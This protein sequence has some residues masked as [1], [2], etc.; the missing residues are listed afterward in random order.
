MPPDCVGMGAVTAEGARVG[1][2]EVDR[3]GIGKRPDGE[4]RRELEFGAG[5]GTGELARTALGAGGIIPAAGT[6]GGVGRG[7]G[8]STGTA[9]GAAGFGPGKAPVGGRGGGIKLLEDAAPGA[10]D[11]SRGTNSSVTG[12][13][14]SSMIFGCDEGGAI[15]TAGGESGFRRRLGRRLLAQNFLRKRI[16]HA[17]HRGIDGFLIRAQGQQIRRNAHH[18]VHQRQ[19]DRKGEETGQRLDRLEIAGRKMRRPVPGASSPLCRRGAVPAPCSS[20][21]RLPSP[22]HPTPRTARYPPPALP[23]ADTAGSFL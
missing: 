23:A 9:G 12:T 4:I 7:R 17:S 11:M 2:G 1:W 20:A 6:A 14:L 8:G 3:T 5:G 15:G 22:P 21:A 19:G 18:D 16:R 13:W 10:C